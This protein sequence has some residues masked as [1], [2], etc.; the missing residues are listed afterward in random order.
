MG[1]DQRRR[2]ATRLL[3]VSYAAAALAVVAWLV[4]APPA[5]VVGMAVALTIVLTAFGR[6]HRSTVLEEGE[7]LVEPEDDGWLER[8]ARERGPGT[9]QLGR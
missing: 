6:R 2:L 4:D 7:D 8:R 9:G 1:D 3:V 5:L